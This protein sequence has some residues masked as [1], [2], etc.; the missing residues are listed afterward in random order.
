MSLKND[1]RE[2]KKKGSKFPV[3]NGIIFL[4]KK[5]KC[6]SPSKK[7][8]PKKLNKIKITPCRKNSNRAFIS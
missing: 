7:N 3:N 6:C 5:Q 1:L 4:I 8:F 2:L